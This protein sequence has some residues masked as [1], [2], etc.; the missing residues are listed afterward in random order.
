MSGKE[1][2]NLTE[3]LLQAMKVRGATEVFGIPGDFALPLFREIERSRLL[4]LV[5]LSHEPGVGFAADA[6]ARV[7][8][9]LG[10]AA[11]TY[12]AGA[13]NLVN[14]VASAYA[15]RVPLV[16]LSGAPAA[17]ES[18]SGLLLHHQVKTLDSQWRLFE[19]LTVDRARLDDPERAP[20]QIARVLDA[21]LARSRPVYLE[22]PRDMPARPCAEVPMSTPAVP[23]PDRLAACADEVLAR[24]TAAERPVLMVGVEVRRYDLEARVAELARRLGVPVVTSFMG[25]GLLAQA[26]VPLVGTYLGLAGDAAVSERVESSD[27]LLLL[28]V[29]VSDTNFAVS[30]RRIDLRKT[31][32]V[33]DG[34]VMLGHHVYQDLP[35]G[36][37]V[38]ALLARVPATA[39]RGLPMRAAVP[40]TPL[41]IADDA[42]ITPAHIA[43]AVNGLFDA[44]GPMPLASD[45]GDCLFVAMDIDHATLVAPGYYATM[46]YGVPAGLGLQVA[47]GQRPIVLVGDGAFQMTGW[48][49]GNARRI[50]C[51]PIVL[52]LNNASWEML[53]TFEPAAGF[54][55][56]SRWDFASM[57]AGMGGDGQA[58]R[59][60]GELVAAL[61]RAHAARGRFQL[62][63]IRLEPG[64][65]SPTLARFVQ[66]VRRLSTAE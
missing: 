1:D 25:R 60:R 38:D 42:A 41:P 56:L 14:T 11:V 61:A 15:E 32:Q 59:T 43:A 48:E 53:R 26:D 39:P 35:I 52:V 66:A 63:D 18:A 6:A 49:L 40:A 45:I 54:N 46:G 65:L 8:G 27:G 28:G 47:T 20:A 24:L 62:I 37:L 64:V 50:G 57:A 23:D 58:V 5:T 9:G 31:I 13:F 55:D 30:A 22:M 2:V 4:P 29:I 16:V 3:R 51:D 19:E 34:N 12:G 21:A 10:V 36:A 44:H 17:S 7:R 33:Y